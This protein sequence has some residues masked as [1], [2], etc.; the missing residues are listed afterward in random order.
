MRQEVWDLIRRGMHTS[1]PSQSE[2]QKGLRFCWGK[3]VDAFPGCHQKSYRRVST[4]LDG[5]FVGPHRAPKVTWQLRQPHNL[6]SEVYR[7][8]APDISLLLCAWG[9]DAVSEVKP[10]RVN[11]WLK[12]ISISGSK[13]S[14]FLHWAVAR[15]HFLVRSQMLSTWFSKILP[16]WIR[17][18]QPPRAMQVG[19]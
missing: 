15:E 6:R 13:S 19:L 11:C 12:T 3:N 5:E 8:V 1:C 10:R 2:V 14:N 18:F 7:D 16:V 9:N 17:L 4:C